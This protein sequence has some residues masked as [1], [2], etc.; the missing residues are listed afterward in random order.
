MGI[1]NRNRME[2]TITWMGKRFRRKHG[3]L[4]M[5]DQAVLEEADEVG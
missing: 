3:G 2:G 1:G 5:R 4:Q